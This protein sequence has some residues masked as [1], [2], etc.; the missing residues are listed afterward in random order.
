MASAFARLALRSVPRCRPT[1][2]LPRTHT[3]SKLRSLSTT[4]RKLAGPAYT[5][6]TLTEEE[7]NAPQDWNDV[8]KNADSLKAPK[9]TGHI[10]N[11][12]IRHYTVNFVS[13]GFL[14]S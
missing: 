12:K 8:I 10:D 4:T 1:P 6:T 5:P 7:L 3:S 2:R 13:S 14:K 9:D 11:K